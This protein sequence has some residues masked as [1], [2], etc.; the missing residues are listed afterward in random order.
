MVLER[1]V[2]FM[3]D[4]VMSGTHHFVG[5]A[6]PPGEHPMVFNVTWGNRRIDRF[7]NP[8]GSDFMCNFLE[9]TVTVGGLVKD[10]ACSGKLDLRYFSEAKIRYTF[11]FEDDRGR[12]YH[13]VGK[14]INIRPWNLHRTHTTCYGT[15]TDMESGNV[16]SRSVLYFRLITVPGFLLS[17]RLG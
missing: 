9:G 3:V 2:G 6:G 11:T 15:V 5:D 14:K 17:F 12:S 10:A 8:L 13:Y 16:I 1:R 4:E 7:F